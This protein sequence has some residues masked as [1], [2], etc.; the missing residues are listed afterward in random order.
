MNRYQHLAHEERYMIY[1]LL[2]KGYSIQN[3]ASQLDRSPSTISREIRRNKGMRGYRYIQAH[4]LA[5]KRLK[6]A[7]RS[8]YFS[9]A[10]YDLIE[11]FLS[12]D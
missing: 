8:V 1:Q 4:G 6:T 5:Q 9:P 3:I 10:T 2:R 12:M 11:G 7:H